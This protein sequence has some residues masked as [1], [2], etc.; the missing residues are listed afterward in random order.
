MSA[1]S[2][3]MQEIDKIYHK[4]KTS[5]GRINQITDF[6]ILREKGLIAENAR[7]ENFIVTRN[8]VCTYCGF[9][10]VYN[11]EDD[12]ERQ[13]ARDKANA[14]ALVCEKDPRNVELHALQER[15]KAAEA[16]IILWRAKS[17]E[18]NMPTDKCIGYD[19]C[20]DDLEKALS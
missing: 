15:V 11:N 5:E 8:V 10:V 4:N 17:D 1:D 14:H 3:L 2:E 6:V 7:L 19:N 9:K 12:E 18:G 20:A 13:A 16:L